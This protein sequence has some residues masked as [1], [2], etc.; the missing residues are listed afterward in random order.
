MKGYS[1][2]YEKYLAAI[3]STLGSLAIIINL[4]LK[5]WTA[6]NI[7]DS[8]AKLSG[9]LVTVIVFLIAMK[10]VSRLNYS[11][12]KKAF[13]EYL[14]EWID[15]NRFLIDEVKRKEGKE[16]K[17]FYYMLTK[18]HHNNLI[19]QQKVAN[20]FSISQGS[21]YHKGVFLYTD[22]KDEEEII[23]G[24]NKSF[25]ISKRGGDLPKPFN[26]IM[27]IAESFKNRIKEHF[28]DKFDYINKDDAGI[29]IEVTNE[30]KRLHISIKKIANTK[31]NAKTAIDML[32]YIKTL[33]IALA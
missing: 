32:E 18:Q 2:N 17:E 21:I 10:T 12:F 11:N 4:F 30:G 22:Y 13:E 24:L 1:N 9:L 16:N 8:L 25:F 5:G 26:T 31:D 19:I 33:I 20:D 15:Q 7:L 23:I 3:F 28:E 29:P 14:Q 6:E 27:D